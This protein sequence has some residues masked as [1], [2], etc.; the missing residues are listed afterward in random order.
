MLTINWFLFLWA[1]CSL[2][3]VHKLA[4]TLAGSLVNLLV[5]KNN[6][7]RTGVWWNLA[8]WPNWPINSV[9][10]RNVFGGGNPAHGLVKVTCERHVVIPE[11]HPTTL[12]HTYFFNTAISFSRL[13]SRKAGDF[14]M[15]FRAKSLPVTLCFTRN[16]SEKAPLK[17]RCQDISL[18]SD[19]LENIL[20]AK[21]K[22]R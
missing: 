4:L 18:S 7:T 9:K 3:Y 22:C 16:T 1:N 19:W 13:L 12:R 15:H 2:A 6:S 20:E 11:S 8:D 21:W 14:L 5:K 10:G 17:G